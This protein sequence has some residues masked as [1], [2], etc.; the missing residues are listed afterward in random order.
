MVTR[1]CDGCGHDSGRS[2]RRKAS[3]RCGHR[4]LTRRVAP[5]R[6]PPQLPLVRLHPR[7]CPCAAL[8]REPE[9]SSRARAA[10]QRTWSTRRDAARPRAARHEPKHGRRRPRPRLPSALQLEIARR[11]A[12]P[13]SCPVGSAGAARRQLRSRRVARSRLRRSAPSDPT[14]LRPEPHYFVP[15]RF[16]SGGLSRMRIPRTAGTLLVL[17]LLAPPRR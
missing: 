12:R 3:P 9:V 17:L 4:G 14:H 13:S 15:D 11:E 2:W 1:G 10:T 5:H 7:A 16:H 6:E 8:L